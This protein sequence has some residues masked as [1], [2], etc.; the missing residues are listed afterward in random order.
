MGK[1]EVVRTPRDG[2]KQESE[3]VKPWVEEK[4]IDERSVG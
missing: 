1:S 3:D 4:K 2:G